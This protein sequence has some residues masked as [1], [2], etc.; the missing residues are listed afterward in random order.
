MKKIYLI[1]AFL[2]SLNVAFS[3]W[4][5]AASVPATRV[6]GFLVIQAAGDSSEFYRFVNAT[7]LKRLP[8]IIRDLNVALNRSLFNDVDFLNGE[9]FT[10]YLSDLDSKSFEKSGITQKIS[11]TLYHVRLNRFNSRATDKALAVTL[12]HET[13]HCLLLD[14]DR[15][16]RRGDKKAAAYILRFGLPKN[17]RSNFFPDEFFTL[18]NGGEAGQHELMHQLFYSHMVA[19]LKDFESIHENSFLDHLEAEYLMWSGLQFTN[20]YKK[21]RDEEKFEIALTIRRAKGI[22]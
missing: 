14:L 6:A 9:G 7:S 2:F 1:T 11:D 17:H 3:N 10:I 16:A 22:E 13:M 21:L 8:T 5:K 15:K 19:L 18:M 12:I 4:T 20:A